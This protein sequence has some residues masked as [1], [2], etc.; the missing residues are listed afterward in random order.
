MADV[1]LTT[2]KARPYKVPD[3][4]T[5]LNLKTEMEFTYGVPSPMAPGV[6]RIVANNASKLTF[7]GTNTYVVGSTSLAVIDPGPENSQHT[8]AI[9]EAAQG[10]PISHIVIT[11][12][13]RDHVEGVARLKAKTGAKVF[14]FARAALKDPDDIEHT[15]TEF[16]DHEFAPDVGLADGDR[17][18]GQDWEL[19]AIHTP[20]HSPDHLCFALEG[21]GVVFS[22]DHVM[23]WNTSIIAPPEGRMSDY[24]RSLEKLLERNDNVFLPGH[25]GRVGAPRRT[26]KAYLLHR[27][28]RE[29][30]ILDAVRQGTN[31]IRKLVPVIYHDLDKD[32]V[33]AATMSLRAHVEH[34]VERGIIACDDIADVDC[35]V[36]SSSP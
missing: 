4:S 7:K 25:G 12:A 11:H 30:A 17:I 36:V 35:A 23:A 31:T 32:I 5:D 26:V 21:R 27:R 22:G 14:A 29:Q 28:W 9:L 8:R 20:G 6:A 16:T 34:L 2:S 15:S 10:R 1:R 33:G 13:H 24:L 19:M 3:M 18:A